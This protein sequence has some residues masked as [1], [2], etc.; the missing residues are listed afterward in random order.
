LPKVIEEIVKKNRK[1]KVRI[2]LDN[3]KLGCLKFEGNRIS[4]AAVNLVHDWC[5]ILLDDVIE[6]D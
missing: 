3:K 6:K 4:L 5:Q 2:D 1:K